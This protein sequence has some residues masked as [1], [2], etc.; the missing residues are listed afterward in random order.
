MMVKRAG[1][2]SAFIILAGGRWW[3]QLHPDDD[4]DADADAEA[5][6]DADADADCRWSVEVSTSC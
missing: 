6:A 5:K 2:T 4:A 3:Y 1:T